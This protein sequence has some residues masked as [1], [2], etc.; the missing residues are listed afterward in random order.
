MWAIMSS[1]VPTSA[2]TGIRGIFRALRH[3]N[4]QLFFAGQGVSL[5]GTWM[6][7]V[8]QSWLVYE[9]TRNTGNASFWLGMIGFLGSLPIVL[10]SL[11]GGV[12]A[13]RFSKRPLILG[14]QSVALVLAFVLGTLTALGVVQLWH[15]GLLAFLLG[16]VQAFDMP[17]RQSFVVEMVGREDLG[18]AIALNS[19]IFNTARLIGPAVAGALIASV[20]TAACF[21]LNSVSFL[22][23]IRSEE[24][25]SELQ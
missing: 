17:A 15:V 5:V 10:F 13:D 22:A 14:T 2:T 7:S 16:V 19:A 9:I 21:F 18:N 3:R 20:G 12:V 8:A 24:H 1:A 11:F 4:Y 6:Q 23:V 25:T